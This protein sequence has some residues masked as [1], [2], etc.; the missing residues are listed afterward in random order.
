M[1]SGGR[2]WFLRLTVCVPT[3]ERQGA[4][5][6]SSYGELQFFIRLIYEAPCGFNGRQEWSTKS[7]MR[8]IFSTSCFCRCVVR[9]NKCIGV[10]DPSLALTKNN[11][12]LQHRHQPLCQ[13]GHDGKAIA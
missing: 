8:H 12:L 4:N 2:G 9:H 3:E 13:D 5:E 6:S 11:W 10:Y 1:V 7:F